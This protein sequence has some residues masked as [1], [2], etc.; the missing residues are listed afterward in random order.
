[1]ASYLI[2][3]AS[4]GLGLEFATQLSSLPTSSVSTIIATGRTQSTELQNL[5]STS[6]GKVVFVQM[7]VSDE[8]SVKKA[9][10]EVEKVLAG[11]GLDVLINNVGVMPWT[12]GGIAKM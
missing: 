8:A 3:G 4:R 9:V 1:M 2:T 6:T 10:P 12:T 5:I 7:D 11:K